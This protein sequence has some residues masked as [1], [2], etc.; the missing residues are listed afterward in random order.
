MSKYITYL[1]FSLFIIATANSEDAKDHALPLK[2]DIK[3][4]EK[5]EI[6][7]SWEI[8]TSALKYF[9][10]RKKIKEK[11]WTKLAELDSSFTQ[12]NDLNVVEGEAYEYAVEKWLQDYEAYGYIFAGKSIPAYSYRGKV[13]LIIDSTLADTLRFEINRYVEDLIGDGWQVEKVAVPRTER[14]DPNA[15]AEVKEIVDDYYYKDSL[16]FKTI[17]LIG[18][19]AVPYSGLDAI[20][21]HADHY[22]AWPADLYYG[23]IDGNWTDTAAAVTASTREE[24]YN[25]PGDGKFDQMFIPKD[26][27]IQ[28]GRLDFYNLPDFE[29]SEVELLKRYFDKNHDYRNNI[30]TARK[31][32]LIDDNFNMYSGEGFASGAWINFTSLVGADSIKAGQFMQDLWVD[33]YLFAYGCASGAYTSIQE[34][35]YADVFADKDHYGV[36]TFLF[37]SLAGDWDSKNNILRCAIASEPSILTCSW[38]GRPFWFIH[39]M[40]LGETMG[41]ATILSQN[42]KT[43]YKCS[44]KYGY[45]RTHTALMGDPTL[46]LNPVSPVENLRIADAKIN[47]GIRKIEIEWDEPENEDIIGYN[48]YRADNIYSKFEKLNDEPVKS[49]FYYDEQAL[50]INNAYLVRP[51]VLE[52]TIAGTYYNMGAGSLVEYDFHD[53]PEKTY[54]FVLPNPAVSFADIYIDIPEAGKVEISAYSVTGGKSADIFKGYINSG[55]RKIKWAL[56]DNFKNS[57]APGV[58]LIK[59]EY[60]NEL[61]TAKIVVVR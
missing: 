44:G 14:F 31:R 20:D 49:V 37:G 17:V 55:P 29:E 5:N 41:D 57:I 16:N 22:G 8:D 25:Y 45:R 35:A 19:I 38:A 1:L 52:E 23:V 30:A 28:I 58:Y 33:D 48:I 24:N 61:R 11:S 6:V 10:K 7:I 50:L 2:A 39:R 42:N 9:V 59:F 4:P 40:S 53:D 18:R 27:S 13:L 26:V 15:V 47:K 60:R 34:V 12:Y 51:L 54:F 21:G 56:R 36:F 32:A 3:L 43:I 46:R